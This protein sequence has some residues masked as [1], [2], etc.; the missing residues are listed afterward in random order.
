MT[1]INKQHFRPMTKHDLNEIMR[2]EHLAYPFPWTLSIFQDCL[3]SSYACWLLLEGEKILGYGVMTIAVD[4][5]S[6]LN[7]CIQPDYH[8]QGLG[9][10][11]LQ[12]LLAIA[13]KKQAKTMFLEVRESNH[14]ARHLYESLGFNEVGLRSAYYPATPAKK[15]AANHQ[16]RE[17]ALVLALEL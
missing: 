4:E 11:L 16:N 10:I 6:L 2:I 1:D 9:K 3:K 5:A 8:G 12:F 17:D 15:S 13:K 7:I 14:N